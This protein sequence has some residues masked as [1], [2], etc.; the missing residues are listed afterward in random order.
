MPRTKFLSPSPM[1]STAELA[2]EPFVKLNQDL[3]SAAKTLT[4]QEAR[5]FVDRYYQIQEERKRT[6]NQLRAASEGREPSALLLWDSDHVMKREKAVL[7]MLSVFAEQS[8]P[9]RWLLSIHGIGPVMTAGLLAYIDIAKAPTPSSIWSFAGRNP[10]AKWLGREKANTLYHDIRE[11]FPK[12]GV[13]LQDLFPALSAASNMKAE[14]LERWARAYHKEGQLT[15]EN[16]VKA[17]SRC[18][19]NMQLKLLT[20]KIAEYGFVRPST[21]EKASL[22]SL[23]YRAR[24]LVE[25]E[26][27]TSGYYKEA[28]ARALVERT[29]RD[30]DLRATYESGKLPDGQ[31]DRRARIYAIKLF[32]SHVHH[33]FYECRYGRPPV[34]PY[35][36]EHDPR[37]KHYVHPSAAGW[38]PKEF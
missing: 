30:G 8:R 4:Q 29:I 31:I 26:R 17:L 13:N 35:I 32:L 24:K 38:N 27:N 23:T 21:S 12:R 15:A 28:A 19:W 5:Y 1:P 37:H 10:Q 34:M 36:F 9:G 6:D 3:L 25:V 33:V 14:S 18:P 2:F 20:Y 11:T 7:A 16:I 22:Y